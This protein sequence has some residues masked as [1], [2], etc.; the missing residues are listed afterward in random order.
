MAFVTDDACVVVDDT[1]IKLQPRDGAGYKLGGF[2]EGAELRRVSGVAD[3][4][5]DA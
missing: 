2:P 4:P 1:E 3:H 5:D